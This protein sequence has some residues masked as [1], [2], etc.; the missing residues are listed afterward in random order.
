MAEIPAS[1]FFWLR[2]TTIICAFQPLQL[3]ARMHCKTSLNTARAVHT[4]TVPTHNSTHS[5][6]KIAYQ[7][8]SAQLK[9]ESIMS[10]KVFT[11]PLKTFCCHISQ[12]LR[13]AISLWS[14]SS[15]LRVSFPFSDIVICLTFFFFIIL[16]FCYTYS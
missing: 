12:H 16:V 5:H 15:A 14:L 6:T 7:S 11:V 9:E 10:L 8:L 4:N 3:P 2:L 1:S 13:I